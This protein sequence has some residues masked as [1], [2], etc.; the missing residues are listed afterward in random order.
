M[1]TTINPLISGPARV[2][3]VMDPSTVVINVGAEK[4]VKRGDRFIVLF[5]EPN[6]L[7]DPDT[8]V[9]LGRL[10]IVRGTGLV[11]HVQQHMATI[12]S[13]RVESNGR[14]VTR[15]G[16]GTNSLLASLT[17]ATTTEYTDINVLPFNDVEVGDIARP[18]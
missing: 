8:G 6:E 11:T 13:D 9:H 4:G 10:E 3:R 7:V 2:V 14:I 15:G 1:A 12:R 18:V 17:Q 16:V 5:V